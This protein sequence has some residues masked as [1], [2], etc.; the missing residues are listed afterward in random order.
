MDF[1]SGPWTGF[2]N[3]GVGT[4]RYRMDLSLAF[5]NGTM[6]GDGVDNVGRFLI[7]GHYD[8]QSGE[9]SW[10]KTYIGAHDVYYR[11]FR[12]GK[13]IWGLW[14]L[15]SVSGGFQIWPLGEEGAEQEAESVEEPVLTEL[16]APGRSSG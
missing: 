7:S 11:G 4:G 10:T 9:C 3:Y 2:Y 16:Y 12:E 15:T 6:S 5:S 14:E 1:P 13:G 8:N